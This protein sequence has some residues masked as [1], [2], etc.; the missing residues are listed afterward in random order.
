MWSERKE[1]RYSVR[2]AHRASACSIAQELT[3]WVGLVEGN[4][5]RPM[6]GVT[7]AGLAVPQ[8]ERR[9]RQQRLLLEPE[10]DVH[11]LVPQ[12]LPGELP[13]QG[14]LNGRLATRDRNSW[15]HVR[16]PA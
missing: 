14:P 10:A 2:G 16:H 13:D 8:G 11:D 4:D 6:T 1:G 9:R 15:T 12:D 5:P 3:S 7:R